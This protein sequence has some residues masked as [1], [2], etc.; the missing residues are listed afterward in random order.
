[1]MSFEVVLNGQSVPK[2]EFF[3][4]DSKTKQ[5]HQQSFT[6]LIKNAFLL[7][8]CSRSVPDSVWI[9]HRHLLYT[10]HRPVVVEELQVFIKVFN[11]SHFHW[12]RCY[13]ARY[14]LLFSISLKPRQWNDCFYF[15]IFQILIQGTSNWHYLCFKYI[16]SLKVCN[17][18]GGGVLLKTVIYCTKS[19]S[20]DLACPLSVARHRRAMWRLK[21]GD[22]ED[23]EIVLWSVWRT[24]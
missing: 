23:L 8:C 11:I 3:N 13:L 10:F 9:N 4:A 15:E 21:C 6:L 18:R 16:I 17:F 7:N 1:M 14:W 12:G 5:C 2:L 22:S 20:E 24:F 19:A